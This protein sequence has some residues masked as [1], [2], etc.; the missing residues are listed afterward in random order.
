MNIFDDFI[1]FLQNRFDQYP[2]HQYCYHY[3]DSGT[4]EDVRRII[5]GHNESSLQ[6]LSPSSMTLSS[7]FTTNYYITKDGL[8]MNPLHVLAC[9][10]YASL[11]VIVRVFNLF[12]TKQQ[13]N[14]LSKKMQML[15]SDMKYDPLQLY[16]KS[17]GMASMSL[18]QALNVPAGMPWLLIKKWILPQLVVD[19]LNLGCEESADNENTRKST[20]SG[21]DDDK[22]IFPFMVAAK[23]KNCD[24]ETVYNL[25][26][27]SVEV[28][29]M[30]W[31]PS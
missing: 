29:S 14:I 11:D 2:V 13:K 18:S 17:R 22:K 27:C 10:Q 16:L 23:Q 31:N 30:W 15:Q 28:I 1:R 6:P 8:D 7:S 25:A 20:T 9:N 24:L 5:L 19:E 26:M 4:I 12:N 3:P 21:S